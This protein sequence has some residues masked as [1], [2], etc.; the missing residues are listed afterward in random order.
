MDNYFNHPAVLSTLSEH[1]LLPICEKE[2]THYLDYLKNN[3]HSL[4]HQYERHC[5]E[6]DVMNHILKDA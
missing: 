6:K 5:L 2:H 3:E 1:E 4:F